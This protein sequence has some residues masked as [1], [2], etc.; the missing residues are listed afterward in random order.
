MLETLDAQSVQSAEPTSL[1]PF[2]RHYG[3][4]VVQ[5]VK[6]V[7]Y[8]AKPAD[9]AKMK[10]PTY[11][12]PELGKTCNRPGAYDAFELPSLIGSERRPY[13]FQG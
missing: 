12:C 7:R 11:A 1:V 4:H 6:V 5:K 13:R 3:A 10:R 2:G 9:L 8:T